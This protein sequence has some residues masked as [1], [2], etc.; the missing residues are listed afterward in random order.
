[1]QKTAS[2][3]AARARRAGAK[4]CRKKRDI[5]I[6]IG[7]HTLHI[8]GR[9]RNV[10]SSFHI[11]AQRGDATKGLLAGAGSA[12]QGSGSLM[13]DAAPVGNHHISAHDDAVQRQV[14]DIL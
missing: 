12:R 13:L 10:F 4:E 6:V 3:K 14:K 2:T 9:C 11:L 7:H 8:V 5:I 1:M